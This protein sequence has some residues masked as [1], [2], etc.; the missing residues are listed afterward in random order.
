[1]A[2]EFD[3]GTYGRSFAD[4][5]D[6]WYPADADTTAAVTH[7]SGLCSA[8]SR[9]L[10]LGVGTGRLAL[11]L[12][13]AGHAVTG[14]DS[15]PEMLALLHDK[16]DGLGLTIDARCGDVR[17]E[18]VWPSGPFEL[19]LAAFNF[20]FNL[21][22]T[23]AKADVFRLAARRLGTAGSLVVESFVPLR[24]EGG[25]AA[26]RHLELKELTVDSVLLIASV[27]EPESGLVHG[28]HIELRDGEPVRLRPWRVHVASTEELTALATEA[29]LR[30]VEH[31]EDWSGTPFGADSVRSI[32]RFVPA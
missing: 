14:I 19:V 7:L 23:E 12:A 25:G 11:P 28:Q 10:E 5:Y 2:A 18:Q 8:P 27:A 1:M 20:V 16:A 21:I 15:S 31:H 6:R 24:D 29:G 3:A 13:A 9:V 22:G 4:V 32:A 26:Q 30:L 17:D